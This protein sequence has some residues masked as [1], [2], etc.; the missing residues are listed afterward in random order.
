MNATSGGTSN[1]STASTA[2]SPI[3]PRLNTT[4][5]KLPTA[6]AKANGTDNWCH[7]V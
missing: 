4:S 6:K 7:R 5:M 3:G 2:A 1:P